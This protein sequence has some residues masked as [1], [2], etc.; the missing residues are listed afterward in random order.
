MMIIKVIMCEK[1]GG[2]GGDISRDNDNNNNENVSHYSN[3][4]GGLIP[5]VI[6]V[7][8]YIFIS[9]VGGFL[10]YNIVFH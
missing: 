4:K 1:S 5:G 3:K 8:A 10:I 2:S 9:T 6:F 7:I